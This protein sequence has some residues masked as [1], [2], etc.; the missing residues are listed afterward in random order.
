M[1][2]IR[3]LSFIQ[4]QGRTQAVRSVEAQSDEQPP[5][6][7]THA[8]PG[9]NSSW[10]SVSELQKRQRSVVSLRSVKLAQKGALPVVR[11]QLQFK[12]L[13]LGLGVHGKGIPVVHGSVSE[14]QMPL[15][16][17]LQVDVPGSQMPEQQSVLSPWQGWPMSR[18]PNSLNGGDGSAGGGGG[19]TFCFGLFLCFL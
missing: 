16:W 7:T 19:G 1:I 14:K 8:A 12:S 4:A 10:Q 18:Q 11:V 3:V 13:G 9:P 5:R 17:A 2:I 15:L 6:R